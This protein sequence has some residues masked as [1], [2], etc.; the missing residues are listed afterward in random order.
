MAVY[1][2]RSTGGF[3]KLGKRRSR[4]SFTDLRR[5]QP[6]SLSSD[7]II[8]HHG[9]T[10]AAAETPILWPPGAESDSL[11]KTLILKTEERRRAGGEGVDRG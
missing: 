10:D 8:N 6:C 4:F 5:N 11:D 9:R 3:Q 7:V 2:S 1:K